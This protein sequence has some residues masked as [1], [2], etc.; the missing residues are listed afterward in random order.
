MFLLSKLC[1]QTLVSHF[2]SEP[3]TVFDRARFLKYEKQ[4][5]FTKTIIRSEYSFIVGKKVYVS[6]ISI[7][8]KRSN[9]SS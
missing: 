3:K 9:I 2:Q 5:I 4:N 1:M 8:L 7:K 6:V